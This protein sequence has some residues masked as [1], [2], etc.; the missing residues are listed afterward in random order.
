MILDNQ[1]TETSGCYQQAT[2]ESRKRHDNHNLNFEIEG[3][4]PAV[5]GRP[6]NV[7]YRK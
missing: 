1:P 7:R 5:F 6:L 3:A 4:P 2:R